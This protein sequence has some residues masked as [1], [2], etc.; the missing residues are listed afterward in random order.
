MT[1]S[2][3]IWEQGHEPGRQVVAL[4]VAVALTAVVLDVLVTEQVG[5]LFDLVFVPL[6]VGLALMVRPSD[7]FTVGVLPPL[8]MV[9]VFL[10]LAATTPAVIAHPDDNVLQAVVSGLS[11]HAVALALGYG[12]CLGALAVRQRVLAQRAGLSPRTG[13][14]PQ[15]PAG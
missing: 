15:H 8:V 10:L 11:S 13:P 14:G 6:S 9:G 4:A 3:T 7:F 2:R 1:P 5:V 12:L